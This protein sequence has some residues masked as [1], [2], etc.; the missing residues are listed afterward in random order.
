[1]SHKFFTNKDCEYYPCHNTNKEL[2]CLFCFCPLYAL[3]EN[4]GG[5]PKYTEDGLKDCSQCLLPHNKDNYDYI[6]SRYNDIMEI[7]KKGKK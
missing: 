7:A 3:G 5:N 6:L 2:N 4:C 1:M